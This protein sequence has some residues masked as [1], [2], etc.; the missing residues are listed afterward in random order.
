MPSCAAKTVGE[1]RL[2]PEKK[3]S[4]NDDYV[5]F[6]QFKLN[7]ADSSGYI[8]YCIV[9]KPTMTQLTNTK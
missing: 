8:S 6:N 4:Q 3:Y 5:K 2:S 7:L 1:K 9:R